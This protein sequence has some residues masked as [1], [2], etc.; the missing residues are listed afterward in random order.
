MA[1]FAQIKEKICASSRHCVSL[2]LKILFW[3]TGQNSIS[4]QIISYIALKIPLLNRGFSVYKAIFILVRTR[5]NCAE[6]QCQNYFQ[7]VTFAYVELAQDLHKET[8]LKES[9]IE[10][11]VEIWQKMSRLSLQR[12]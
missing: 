1:P 4:S 8:S 5:K 6:V 3:L 10:K 12:M 2:R 9:P 11:E 7:S